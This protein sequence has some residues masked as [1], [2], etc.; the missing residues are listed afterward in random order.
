VPAFPWSC[1]R[2][3]PSPSPVTCPL[4]YSGSMF[5]QDPA[6]PR[7]LCALF[8]KLFYF[9]LSPVSRRLA[10]APLFGTAPL[11]CAHALPI[12][13]VLRLAVVIRSPLGDLLP[14]GLVCFNAWALR[15]PRA[16]TVSRSRPEQHGISIS[17]SLS[18]AM[19]T[20]GPCFPFPLNLT[21]LFNDDGAL[22]YFINGQRPLSRPRVRYRI[23]IVLLS[24]TY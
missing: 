10:G 3:P 8:F 19:G 13:K 22:L 24:K 14:R 4:A 16:Q 23:A 20:A 17:A 11:S 5:P 7:L 15:L 18:P 6:V 2:A 9:S 12:W 21:P 1:I